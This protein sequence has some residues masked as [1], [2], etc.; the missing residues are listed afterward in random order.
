MPFQIVRNDITKMKADAIVNTANPK[1]VYEG[2]TD[3][4]IYEAAGAEK[5]LARRRKIGDIEPGEAAV[6]PAFALDAKYIIHTVGPVWQG[7]GRGEADCLRKCYE[8]SLHL[9]RRHRC[10]S[11]AF[12]L[13]ASGVYGYPKEEALR[14]ALSVIRE[15][16][17]KEDMMIYLV[18]FDQESFELSGTL[19]A[20]IKTYIDENYAAEKTVFYRRMAERTS[21]RMPVPRSMPRSSQT[22]GSVQAPRSSQTPGSVQVPRSSQA[23]M[24][25]RPLYCPAAAGGPQSEEKG[26]A[27]RAERSLEDVMAQLGET[28]QQRLFR[29]IDERK[30][31]DVEVYKKANLDRKL[32]SKIR[33]NKEYRPKKITAVALAIALELNL[34][35]TKDLLARAEL[36]LSPSSKFDLIISYFIER[37]IYDIYTINLALFGHGQALLGE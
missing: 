18:V 36:A 34:D 31:T 16:L 22:P 30:M 33:G 8:H 15:F 12:P 24:S 3:Q 32:F 1:P 4:A 2:G 35:E 20:D 27:K 23:S 5:L 7:G 21:S 13:I 25:D 17:S 6:T 37:E 10:R 28:F 26:I 9:A 11:I 29:L 19:F 14:I